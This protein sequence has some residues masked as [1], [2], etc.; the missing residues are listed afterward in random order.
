M[1]SNQYALGETKSIKNTVLMNLDILIYD[2]DCDCIK[3]VFSF[4]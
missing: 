2:R 3:L 4:I 1:P